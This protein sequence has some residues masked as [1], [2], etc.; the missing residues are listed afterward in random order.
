MIL[1][2]KMQMIFKMTPFK[3]TQV[4]KALFIVLSLY[5]FE[6][7]AETAVNSVDGNEGVKPVLASSNQSASD[8]VAG[9]KTASVSVSDTSVLELHAEQWDIARSGESLLVLPVLNKLVTAW[10]NDRQM[11]IEIQYPG[12][13][14]GEFWVQELTDWLVSLGIPSKH[15]ITAPGS[16]SDDMIRFQLIK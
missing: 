15:M 10:I 13:E 2:T 16:G 14:E 7:Y 11:K 3:M 8:K 5:V 4:V 6:C 1:K 9:N 12:G